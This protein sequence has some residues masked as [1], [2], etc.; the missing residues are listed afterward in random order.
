MNIWE[1]NY[2]ICI[3]DQKS[4]TRAAEKLFLSQSALSQYLKK[5]EE[6]MGCAL[7]VRNGRELVLTDAG[8]IYYKSASEILNMANKTMEEINALND[9][10]KKT[11][12]IGITGAKTL[13]FTSR[14]VEHI[15]SA[16]SDYRVRYVQDEMTNLCAQVKARQITC[17]LG[18]INFQ[19]GVESIRLS[20][21]PLAL[22]VSRFCGGYESLDSDEEMNIN[23]FP[24]MR[25]ILLHAGTVHRQLVDRYFT[26]YGYTPVI[27]AESRDYETIYNTVNTSPVATIAS[28]SHRGNM[29]DAHMI[30]LIY[31]P[32]YE[33]GI[34]YPEHE[35]LSPY[36]KA[37]IEAAVEM[38][39][40]FGE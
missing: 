39:G 11:I 18:A 40:S 17:A 27:F 6:R 24:K 16:F 36:L 10:G 14:V 13:L 38:R 28:V 34:I 5:T 23:S 21:Q 32:K 30:R 22:Y 7:F 35:P 29:P 1:L 4:L 8:R 25:F 26:E 33:L 3:A 37:F 20:S 31:P 15:Q 2:F 19:T 12:T 9:I